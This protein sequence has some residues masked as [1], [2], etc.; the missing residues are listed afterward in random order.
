MPS[1]HRI[2]IHDVD[3]DLDP[4]PDWHQNDADPQVN[5]TP[6]LYTFTNPDR[7][8]PDPVMEQ[9]Y[10]QKKAFCKKKQCFGIINRRAA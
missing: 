2:S 9:D 10:R 1:Q 3:S 5:H 4:D 6:N 7:P 8:K